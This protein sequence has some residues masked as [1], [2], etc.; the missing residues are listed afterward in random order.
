MVDINKLYSYIKIIDSRQDETLNC[1]YDAG[2][3]SIQ[4]IYEKCAKLLYETG[5]IARRYPK[6]KL[7]DLELDV[8]HHSKL[9]IFDNDGSLFYLG[10]KLN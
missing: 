3:L 8:F 2:L 10:V 7:S 4:E 5:K 6:D 9:T 1:L